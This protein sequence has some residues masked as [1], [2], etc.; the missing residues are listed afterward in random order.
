MTLEREKE[1][2]DEATYQAEIKRDSRASQV[3]MRAKGLS[4]PVTLLS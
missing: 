2:S 1:V 3:A 4:S